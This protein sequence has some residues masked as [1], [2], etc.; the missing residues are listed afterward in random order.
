MKNTLWN[1]AAACVLA[2][3]LLT[4]AAPAGAQD[5]YPNR[6]VTIVV[7]FAPGGGVDVVARLLAEKLR[8]SLG[9]QVIVDNKAGAS[10]MVGALAVVRAAPDGYTL[11]LG[12]AGETAI[13]PFVYKARM[14]Y[15]PAKDLAPI[16]A[17]VRVP[18]VLVTAPGAPFKTVE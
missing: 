14:Q 2:G 15:A 1:I 9:Q 16:T 4:G 8:A 18:N 12:S 17:V 7:P 13:N 10:G 11:L 5:G 3:C 6:P